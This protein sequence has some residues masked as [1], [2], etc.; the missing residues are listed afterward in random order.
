M[1]DYETSDVYRAAGTGALGGAATG[2]AAGAVIGPWG[3]AAGAVIGG[4]AGAILATSTEKRR[5]DLEKEGEALNKRLAEQQAEA[6][7]KQNAEIDYA[8]RKG[9]M[10]GGNN[11]DLMSA[12]AGGGG[13]QYDRWHEGTF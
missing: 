7:R 6:T 5:Q 10:V 1:A 8:N 11:Q 3:A 13:S 2:A 4:V 12:V 9:Q